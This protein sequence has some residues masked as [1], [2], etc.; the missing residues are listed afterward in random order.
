MKIS[1]VDLL[2]KQT[3]SGFNLNYEEV[4][5]KVYVWYKKPQNKIVVDFL[6]PIIISVDETFVQNLALCIGDG[7]NNPNKRNTHCNFANK[8]L[9]LVKR[10]Y[11]WWRVLG[12]SKDKIYVYA[13]ANPRSDT[14]EVVS[15]VKKILNCKNVKVYF[16][17]RNR[18]PTIV[19]QIGSSVFQGFYL[20]LFTNL[21]NRIIS[22]TVLRRAF[23]AGLF[24]AEGHIK[25]SVYGT[26]ESISYT[27]N[28]KIEQHLAQF[29]K[30]CLQK[31]NIASK[32][33]SGQVYFCSYE[34]MLRFLLLGLAKLYA[35]KED[36]F[37]RLCE[38][39]DLTLHFKPGFLQGLGV[40]YQNI[41]AENLDCSQSAI[42]LC[43]KHNRFNLKSF[44]KAF[45]H[46]NIADMI[47]NVEFAYVRTSR[48]EDK[49][50]ITFLIN[51]VLGNT[52]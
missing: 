50:S 26:P 20:N 52:K 21:K 13:N 35:Q 15:Q 14:R 43:I 24:A 2:P 33:S 4:S 47:K 12:V 29:V 3:I 10:V 28:P 37:K 7:L 36:K 17:V 11:D 9:E 34:Q 1:T 6:F 31:E 16:S 40:R 42:S 39:V 8:N 32:I 19:I 30:A 51:T 48:V 27:F 49:D 25:H 5:D 38:N 46:T 18:E 22:N 44:K 41:L 23:L 45:P